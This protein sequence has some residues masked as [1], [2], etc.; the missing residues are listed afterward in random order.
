MRN[1]TL[2]GVVLA[3][4]AGSLF[5]LGGCLNLQKL[6]LDAAVYAGLEFVTDGGFFDLFAEDAAAAP[7]G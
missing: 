1:K 3:L 5:Q 7:A 4:A 2:K 6:A